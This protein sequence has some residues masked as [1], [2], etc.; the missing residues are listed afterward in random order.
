M[1]VLLLATG[2]TIASV[3]TPDGLAPSLTAKELLS[4]ATLPENMTVDCLDLYNMDSS[5]IQPEEW[6]G[7]AAAVHAACASHDAVII[8]HGTDTMAYTASMLSFLLQN[9][10]IPIILTGSQQPIISPDSDGRVNLS[11]AL[12]AAAGQ[13]GGVT[14]CFGGAVIKGCRAVKTRTSSLKAFESINYPYVGTVANGRYYAL[15]AEAEQRPFR[16]YDTIEPSVALIK[17]I[18]GTSPALLESVIG[19]G[20][21]GL[22][23]EAFGLGGVHNFRRDHAE[24]IRKIIQN[25]LPVVLSTQC[26]YESSTP[27]IY[28]VSRPLMEAGVIPAHDMT[29]EAA[30][31]KLMW[32]LAQ[33]TEPAE[34]GRLMR[35]DLCGEIS[36]PLSSAHQL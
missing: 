23:V 18:P 2:G 9:P 27:S 26:L 21:K 19:C 11:G 28:A 30:V 6:L 16:Y 33:T 31:T 10:P 34:V 22:V 15:M 17:L 29:R 12:L 24:S 5:N 3:G 36:A 25:G 1:K 20:I 4:F 13:G 7:I 8:T 32:V 14:I 35:T